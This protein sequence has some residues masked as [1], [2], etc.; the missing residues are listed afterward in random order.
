M[1][2]YAGT[3]WEAQDGDILRR[4][5]GIC[6]HLTSGGVFTETTPVTSSQ[7]DQYID[8]GYYF[9]V[10]ELVNNG[11]AQTQTDTE[12]KAILAQIQSADAACAVEYS[13]PMADNGEPNTRHAAMAQRR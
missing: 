8:D 4:V 5:S 1:A 10:A 9:V 6:R 2:N 7:V 3:A 11:Y 12:V 13:M